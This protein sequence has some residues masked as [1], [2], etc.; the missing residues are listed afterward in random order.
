MPATSGKV[1]MPHNNRISSSSAL[2][3]NS[4]WSKTIGIDPYKSE[5]EQIDAAAG[6]AASEHAAGLMLLARMTNVSGTGNEMRGGCPKCGKCALKYVLMGT[7]S[8]FVILILMLL[9]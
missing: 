2:N 8:Q 1:R 4:M 3:T 9:R 7:M 6:D 5:Q